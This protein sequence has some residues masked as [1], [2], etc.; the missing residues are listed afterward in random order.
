MYVLLTFTIASTSYQSTTDG[1]VKYAEYLKS[2]YKVKP[3]G[4]QWPP[5]VSKHYVNLSTI[6]SIEDFPKE[7]EVTC[8]LAMIHAKIEE[9]KKLRRSI[10]IDQVSVSMAVAANTL[11][12]VT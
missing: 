1:V 7:K 12:I 4:E 8:T 5:V 6:E 2:V 3:C 11:T 9:V 10:T